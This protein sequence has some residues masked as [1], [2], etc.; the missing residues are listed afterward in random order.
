[1]HLFRFSYIKT[2]RTKLFQVMILS[3]KNLQS[4]SL[5]ILHSLIQY[6]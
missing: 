5:D 2:K 1:M 4:I 3:A 6:R